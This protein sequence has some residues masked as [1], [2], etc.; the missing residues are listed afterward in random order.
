VGL[1]RSDDFERQLLKVSKSAGLWITLSLK[2]C[3]M[4][5]KRY[6]QVPREISVKREHEKLSHL[7]APGRGLRRPRQSSFGWPGESPL[8]SEVA[9]VRAEPT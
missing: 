8:V 6:R 2:A 7:G 5:T 4:H 9:P 1:S 3:A